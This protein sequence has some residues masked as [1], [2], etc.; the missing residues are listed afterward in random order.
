MASKAGGNVAKLREII[1]VADP[2][3][4]AKGD[5]ATDDSTAIQAAIDAAAALLA[6][7]YLSGEHALSSVITVKA[8]A[9]LNCYNGRLLPKGNFDAV[10]VNEGGRIVGPRI[11]CTAASVGVAYTSRVLT[12]SPTDNIIGAKR[13]QKWADDVQIEFDIGGG[14]VGVTLDASEY[15]IQETVAGAITV[16]GGTKVLEL[17]SGDE[18]LEYCNGNIFQSLTGH[19]VDYLIHENPG[20]T[21]DIAGNAYHVM[22]ENN[23]NG[24]AIVLNNYAM[25]TGLL[26]DRPTV[27]FNGDNNLIISSVF[28]MNIQEVTDN[29][30]NNQII[31]PRFKYGDRRSTSDYGDARVHQTSLPGEI[32]FRDHIDGGKIHEKWVYTGV[33][34]PVAISYTLSE[35]GASGIE[36]CKARARMQTNTNLNDTAQITWGTA[37][38]KTGQNPRFHATVLTGGGVGAAEEVRVGLWQDANEHILFIS[39]QANARWICRCTVGG[40]STDQYIAANFN[41]LQFLSLICSNQKITFQHGEAA[42]GSSNIA[43][44]RANMT[45]SVEF[46]SASQF[47]VN[48]EMA[49]LLYIQTLAAAA[50]TLFVYDVQ[51]LRGLLNRTS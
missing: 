37:D 2:A 44:G 46:T 26:W 24:G 30:E 14:G 33:G 11:I 40:V 12:L 22:D 36:F 17:L 13:A 1:S 35:S 48:E 39:D 18:A 10:K 51:L 32:I 4:G 31:T 28:L 50:A 5:G 42:F 43:I 23:G 41:R 15:Y 7:V 6:E 20:T 49:P 34:T 38:V 16:Y 45:N 25:V 21:G 27:T 29:G 9:T 3:Y 19:D 8:G 47:P